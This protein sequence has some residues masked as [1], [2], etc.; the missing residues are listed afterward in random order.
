MY[1]TPKFKLVFLFAMQLS[2]LSKCLY[3]LIKVTSKRETSLWDTPLWDTPLWDTRYR[4]AKLTKVEKTKWRTNNNEH[5]RTRGEGV[6]NWE[7]CGYVLF[8]WP[9]SQYQ[10]VFPINKAKKRNHIAMT[11]GQGDYKIYELF[12]LFYYLIRGGKI[13][14]N[15]NKSTWF[16]LWI[17][18][19]DFKIWPFLSM[20]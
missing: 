13:Y 18:T 15:S 20:L 11:S 17:E 19:K 7:C 10:S 1:D 9:P 2:L 5:E 3:S 12:Y 6:K 8:E 4:A 14:S 16:T